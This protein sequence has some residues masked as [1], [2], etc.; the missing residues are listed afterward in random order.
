MKQMMNYR[1][2]NEN[3]KKKMKGTCLS[4]VEMR[5]EDS[6]LIYKIVG[7]LP[8]IRETSYDSKIST[9][10]AALK[11]HYFSYDFIQTEKESFL[12]ELRIL[13][14]NI[15]SKFQ[16]W[17]GLDVYQVETC[18]NMQKACVMNGEGGVGKTYFVMKLEEELAAREIPHLCIYGKLEKN[19]HRIDFKEIDDFST[20][21]RFV[22][23]IDAIN[24]MYD[25]AQVELCNRLKQLCCNKGLQ[26][27][28]TYRNKTID[29]N[30]YELLKDISRHDYTFA[31]VS[32]ESAI[33]NMLRLGIPD[34]Y[35]YEDLL[36][37]N[38]ALLLSN[39]MN[40]LNSDVITSGRRNNIA[41][42]T[43]IVENGIK[44][45]VGVSRWKDT[46]V[47]ATWMLENEKYI[48]P[49]DEIATKIDDTDSY[50]SIMEQCGY[51]SVFTHN[52]KPSIFFSS[53][54]LMDYLIARAMLDPISAQSPEERVNYI[55]CK[56]QAMPSIK[57]ALIIALFDKYKN[58]YH[59]LKKIL[60]DSDLMEEFSSDVLVKITF[61][62]DDIPAFMD[63]FKVEEP[64]QWLLNI[65]G[66]SNKPFNCIN[67]LNNYFMNNATA[68]IE[69]TDLFSNKHLLGNVIGRLKNLLYFIAFNGAEDNRVDEAYYF[70]LWC[71]A[72]P[73][74]TVRHLSMK[75][76]YD[77]VSRNDE[78][79]HH[80]TEILPDIVDPYIV[81]AIIY[82][83]ASCDPGIM[84]DT[85]DCFLQIIQDK[86]YH[87]AKDLK[88][89][90]LYMGDP[91]MYI[92]WEKANLYKG[93]YSAEVSEGF[94]QI[95]GAVDLMD[96]YLLPFRYWGHN[97]FREFDG[98]VD[99]PK[100][101]ITELNNDL[102]N[103]YKCLRNHYDCRNSDYF[104]EYL[105]KKHNLEGITSLNNKSFAASY[106]EAT[107]AIFEFFNEELYDNNR[108]L[109]SDFPNS[110]LRKLIDIATNYF[111][112][113]IMSNYY[114][115]DFNCYD[116]EDSWGFEIY[117]PLPYNDSEEI[118]ITSPLPVFNNLIEQI[119]FELYDRIELPED[120]DD[121]WHN[122]SLITEKN[123]LNLLK[124]IIIKKEEWVLLS[125]VFSPHEQ[126]QTSIDWQDTYIIYC[127]SSKERHINGKEDR[128]LTIEIPE[129]TGNLRYY[130]L[131]EERPEL[132]KDIRS[133]ST[134]DE[135][136]DSTLVLPPADMIRFFKLTPNYR[137][138]S[139]SDQ[140]GNT[141]ILCD[142]CKKS[143]Y[144]DPVKGIV[145]MKK[146][147]FDEY[148]THGVIK[149]F[150]FTE[151]LI[152][153]K[154][155]S[156]ESCFHYELQDGTITR[157]FRNDLKNVDEDELEKADEECINCPYNLYEKK[158]GHRAETK[159]YHDELFKMLKKYVPS[160][161]SK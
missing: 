25:E 77:I 70:A 50:I 156:N 32:Y 9:E 16:Y 48:V 14:N 104:K 54:T 92:T 88:R 68:Q 1:L 51:L 53:E 38:N 129:Y 137:D 5:W 145:L 66:Y 31:G 152:K 132:C 83:L 133:I 150:A 65:G 106:E 23:V 55:K 116:G 142:N 63:T 87:Y 8:R 37:S 91:H 90:S 11:K 52:E 42:I 155:F 62:Q 160:D 151:R 131:C 123:L 18:I 146:E 121:Q 134:T 33:E 20:D 97:D 39:L 138:M 126:V 43:H 102:N 2:L 89:I 161:W 3:N 113:S 19:L 149:Y 84:Q 135:F 69:L 29:K 75:L 27:L 101:L 120:K 140:N 58:R 128:Y 154:G 125:G 79:R 159:Q 94:Q 153:D 82:S 80:L 148:L 74:R 141:I 67:Y 118:N 109:D 158:I 72:A 44:S 13:I 60:I 124:P 96:K 59:D 24:E 119:E 100:Q 130:Y 21:K 157:K 115:K 46:K 108:K 41:S 76:L 127:C 99:A 122:D 26:V 95:L 40:V 117:D 28:V 143:Y 105:L 64:L 47:I 7:D 45:R 114:K 81:E 49:V 22:L 4:V 78:F 35:K 107:K 56:T 61:E 6:E 86:G 85:K 144:R 112:G 71:T 139:W 30:V 12:E 103:N 136:D 93:D 57:E 98:F 17:Y 10:L 34:V 110:K 36:F 73:N 15:I 147:A 111:M